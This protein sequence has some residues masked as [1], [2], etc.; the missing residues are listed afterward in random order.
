MYHPKEEKEGHHGK[1]LVAKRKVHVKEDLEGCPQR[2]NQ[3]QAGY[4]HLE[5]VSSE[6]ALEAFQ[7]VREESPA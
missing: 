1:D 7:E 2:P 3:E 5:D 4:G 6:V